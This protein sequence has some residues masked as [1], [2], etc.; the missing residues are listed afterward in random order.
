MNDTMQ[1]KKVCLDRYL[2]YNTMEITERKPHKAEHPPAT[3][4]YL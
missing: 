4:S 2:M 1:R 3:G